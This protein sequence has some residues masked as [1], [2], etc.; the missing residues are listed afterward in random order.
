MRL[1]CILPTQTHTFEVLFHK[2]HNHS[3]ASYSP[4]RKQKKSE[5]TRRYI[6]IGKNASII[7]DPTMT[8]I[9]CQSD[10]RGG[11]LIFFCWNVYFIAVLRSRATKTAVLIIRK[12]RQ[13]PMGVPATSVVEAIMAGAQYST[14][15]SRAGRRPPSHTY[16]H[17]H[18]ILRRN[19]NLSQFID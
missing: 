6:R 17:T 15:A 4:V 11:L 9:N 12:D 2:A 16:L 3:H 5:S 19:D 10:P 13:R 8:K 7:R 1:F 14:V 18:H